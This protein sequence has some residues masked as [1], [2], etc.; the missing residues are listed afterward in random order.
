[1]KH[2]Q[3]ESQR[4]YHEVA[5][6]FPLIDDEAF[7][8]LKT[9]IAENGLLEPIWLHPD[10]G[11]IIDG[12][13]RHRACLAANVQPVFKT[14]T[15]DGSLIAFVLSLNLQR[16]HL[17]APQRAAMAVKVLPMLED[18][19]K[20]RQVAAGRVHGRGQSQK[21]VENFPQPFEEVK[22]PAPKARVEAAKMFQVNDR[23]VQDAKR[24]QQDAP[25]LIEK[26]TAGEITMMAAKQEH[27]KRVLP[28]APAIEDTG[29][30]Y[31]VIYADPP[32]QYS[33]DLTTD[34]GNGSNKYGIPDDHYPTMSTPQICAMGEQIKR[35]TDDNAVLFLW[36]TSPHLPEAL[37]VIQAWGFKYKTSF[38]W[39]KV[40]H[41]FG[42]YNSVRHEFLLVATRGA[43]TPDIGEKVPSVQRIER[44][45]RHSEKPEEFRQI[46]DRL[47]THGH[48]IELFARTA[49]EN[50]ETFGNEA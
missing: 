39:D 16:R 3:D 33:N 49:T 50:W 46:I 36:S 28:P 20:E 38:V 40:R 4:P 15:G 43:C 47:Y 27:R 11:S 35:I 23:Y 30:R 7:D 17:T 19:A 2:Y 31:R 1:M 5:N 24:I 8:A 10:D 25:D 18:E 32:W 45:N 13:N 9:D 48:R 14:W 44:S 21:V 42:H 12:R 29:K 26:M 22:E 37:E 41:N 6:I 34:T